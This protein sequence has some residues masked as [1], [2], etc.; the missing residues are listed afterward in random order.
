MNRHFYVN[1]AVLFLLVAALD[2]VDAQGDEMEWRAEALEVAREALVKKYSQ[3][4]T[5]ESDLE[6]FRY[7]TPSVLQRSAHSFAFIVT[8]KSGSSTTYRCDVIVSR[9]RGQRYSFV[10]G[11]PT[12]YKVVC[13]KETISEHNKQ[14]K[15]C[16]KA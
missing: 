3:V 6:I 5:P 8:P 12:C 10:F 7:S 1:L 14:E 15:I 9:Y 4:V 13:T 16:R 11:D 2:A